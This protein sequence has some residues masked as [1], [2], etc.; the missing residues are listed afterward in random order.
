MPRFDTWDSLDII[1]YELASNSPVAWRPPGDIGLK[2]SGSIL[3]VGRPERWM[4]STSSRFVS[5][6]V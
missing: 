3:D 6:M 1:F 5:C 2:H 4:P